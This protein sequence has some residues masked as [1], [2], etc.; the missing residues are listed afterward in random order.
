MKLTLI[1]HGETEENVQGI[2]QGQMPGH[3][4][5]KGKRQAQEV[6]EDLKWPTV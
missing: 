4:T 5:E 6:A 3:L 1:R 2:I